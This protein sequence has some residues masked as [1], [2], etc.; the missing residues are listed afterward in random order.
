MADHDERIKF[1][2][3]FKAKLQA[4]QKS[5]DPKLREWLNQNVHRARNEAI[6]ANTHDIL[7]VYPPPAIAGQA[8]V[9]RLDPFD[10]IFD[11]VYLRSMVPHIVDMLDKTIGVLRNPPPQRNEAKSNP[12]IEF[13]VQ[14]GYAFVVM[15]MDKNDHQLID[16]LEAIK[17]G[18]RECS[19]T[20][21]RIDD[22]ERNERVTDRILEAIRKAEFVIVDLTNERP[23]VFFEAGYAHGLGKIPIYVAREGTHL[24]FDIK[25][26]PV[27]TFRNMKE[28]R[29]GLAKRLVALITSR[30]ERAAHQKA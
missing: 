24:H 4:S 10:H 17:A 14:S 2:E 12:R 19:I 28:L 20:A 9:M 5:N 1:I 29:G 11:N 7:V 23:N 26:Y 3:E 15:P 21:E 6:E 8:P 13:E 27:I 22:D 30:T 18:A 16:V 25:D